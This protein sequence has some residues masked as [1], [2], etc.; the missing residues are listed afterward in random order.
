MTSGSKRWPGEPNVKATVCNSTGPGKG[1]TLI[2]RHWFLYSN[3]IN[4]G[5]GLSAHKRLE[6]IRG[7]DWGG[8]ESCWNETCPMA[9]ADWGRKRGAPLHD[10]AHTIQKEEPSGTS[11][12]PQQCLSALGVWQHTTMKQQTGLETTIYQSIML[13][14][15]PFQILILLSVK[16]Y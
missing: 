9:T 5:I 16:P 4:C 14:S 3:Q 12:I 15:C 1:P 7:K 10:S 8:C 6:A 11:L 2:E 13:P